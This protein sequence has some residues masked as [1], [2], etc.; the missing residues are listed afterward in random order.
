MPFGE[1]VVAVTETPP[2]VEF[3]PA[4]LATLRVTGHRDKLSGNIT[5]AHPHADPTDNSVINYLLNSAGAGVVLSVVLDTNGATSFLL[6]LAA[7]S[8]AELGRAH[9]PQ[10]IPFGFHGRYTGRP[11]E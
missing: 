5:T 9:V 8:F 1:S 7:G 4:T 2:A 10:A 6:V 3:D 11:A